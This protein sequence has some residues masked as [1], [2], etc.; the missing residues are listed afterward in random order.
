[1]ARLT[2]AL[3]LADVNTLRQQAGST[4]MLDEGLK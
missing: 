2:G 3:P 4:E 1:M